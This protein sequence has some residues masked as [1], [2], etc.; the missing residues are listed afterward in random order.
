MKRKAE[1]R[2][3]GKCGREIEGRPCERKTKRKRQVRNRQKET[4]SLEEIKRGGGVG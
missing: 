4:R 3:K 2:R 1:N